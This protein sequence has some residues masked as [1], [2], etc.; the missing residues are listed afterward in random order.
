[1]KHFLAIC[2][3][4]LLLVGPSARPASS[5]SPLVVRAGLAS[6]APTIDGVA[7]PGEWAD[8]ATFS[9]VIA[10]IPATASVMND[11]TNLYLTA[12]FADTVCVNIADPG[13][14]QINSFGL[15]F[16]NAH[17]G[18]LS[19]ADDTL[20]TNLGE[21]SA[22]DNY[23]NGTCCFLSDANA[24]GTNDITGA[25]TLA[26]GVATFELSHPL[27]SGDRLDL[28]VSAG[29]R[30]GFNIVYQSGDGRIYQGFPSANDRNQAAYGD[31]IIAGLVTDTTGPEIQAT[32]AP[33]PNAIGWNNTAVTVDWSVT[34]PESGIASSSG[35]GTTTISEDTSGTILTCSAVNGVSM[36]A[37]GSVTVKVD[38]STPTIAFNGNEDTYTVD[39]TILISCTASDVLSG[40]ATT[41]CP[42]VAS[43]PATD[44]VGSTA[45][46]T[47][48][49]AATASDNA[50]NTATAHTTFTVTVT[51]TGICRLTASLTTGDDIC[52]MSTSIAN[53]PTASAK[54]GK[55]RAFDNFVAA[56]RARSIP[57]DVADLLSRLAHLL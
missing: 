51:A 3:G 40:L 35:C 2:L 16:D 5:H 33:L 57:D 27:C 41:S 17:N 28:C 34:D 52:A 43:G 22:F 7:T 13:R 50:G 10:G 19:A 14:C 54:A 32:V 29:A 45:T 47:T 18:V 31:L 30:V 49:L 4:I 53:A 37:I 11:E 9:F 1:M 48:T 46:T 26:G 6:A 36:S 42:D 56:Q 25:G 24:G 8:A 44:F 55:L 15:F 39:Q 21:N 38:R 12:T 20:V 23:Y